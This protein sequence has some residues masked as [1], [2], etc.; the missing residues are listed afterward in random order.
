MGKEQNLLFVSTYHDH[1]MLSERKLGSNQWVK[2][3]PPNGCADAYYPNNAWEFHKIKGRD[4]YQIRFPALKPDRCLSLVGREG[5]DT[6]IGDD[7]QLEGC[8]SGGDALWYKDGLKV[9]NYTKGYAD[10]CLGLDPDD[11]VYRKTVELRG[12]SGKY[13]YWEFEFAK[14]D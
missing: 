11:Y 2:Q 6:H 13:S 7:T 1:C 5:G 12:C 14:G 8:E 9:K 4:L 3:L 10:L